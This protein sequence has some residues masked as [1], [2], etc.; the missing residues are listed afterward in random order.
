MEAIIVKKP[1]CYALDSP[2]YPLLII[3]LHQKN[4][5]LLNLI[6]NLILLNILIK[7]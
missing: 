4:V 2:L 6:T 3:S 1:R 7:F 5:H